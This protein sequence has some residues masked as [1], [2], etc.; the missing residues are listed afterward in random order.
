[1][2]KKVTCK[3]NNCHIHIISLVI[4]CFL[5][6]AVVCI[7]FYQYYIRDWIKKEHI[8]SYWYEKSNLKETNIKNCTCSHFVDVMKIEDFD[9]DILLDGK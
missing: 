9:F 6:L 2:I 4:I 1:M 8:L 7:G 5:L 3:K